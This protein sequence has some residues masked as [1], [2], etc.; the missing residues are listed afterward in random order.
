MFI[1]LLAFI[2]AAGIIFVN[3]SITVIS[4]IIALL[5]GILFFIFGRNKKP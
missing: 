4:G 5:I 1:L 3:M 2:F